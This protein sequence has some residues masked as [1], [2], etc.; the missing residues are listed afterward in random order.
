MALDTAALRTT[1]A[2]CTPAPVPTPLVHGAAL[3]CARA[4]VSARAPRRARAR[5]PRTA[6]TRTAPGGGRAR[7]DVVPL[8]RYDVR[9]AHDAELYAVADVRCEAFY[10]HAADAYFYP[11][12]RR[13]MHA[14]LAER[15]AAGARCLVA[16]DAAPPQEWAPLAAGGP[17]VVA[18]LD[19]TLHAAAGARVPFGSRAPPGARLYVSSMAVRRA[20]R[21]RGLARRLLESVEDL[22]RTLD[23][24]TVYLHVDASNAAAVR[25]YAS[26]GFEHADAAHR[27][28]PTWLSFLA[29]REHTL[30]R[31]HVGAPVSAVAE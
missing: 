20:W 21:R 18:S 16:A 11:L 5:A 6:A 29:K 3:R 1:A 12:R 8:A 24:G 28:P 4:P 25:L 10:A 14:A 13:E 19:V 2:F 15:V 27:A 17:L 9:D 30:L 26:A 23:V 31:K 7:A 22:A